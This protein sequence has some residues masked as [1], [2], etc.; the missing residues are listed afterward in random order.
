MAL[1]PIPKGPVIDPAAREKL[2]GL[3]KDA[4]AH[5]ADV[6][7]GGHPI[8]G[9]GTFFEPTVLTGVATDS[10]MFGEE[11][12]GP[13]AGVTVFDDLDEADLQHVAVGA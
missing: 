9:H 11:I 10:R 5:G 1:T 13:V 8:E 7:T 2:S 6:R 3:I 12:F 4:V